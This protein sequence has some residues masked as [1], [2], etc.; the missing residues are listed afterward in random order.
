MITHV[1]SVSVYV[2]DQDAAIDFYCNK[3]GFELR[4]DN[5]MGEGLRWVEVAPRGGQTV[6]IL[7]R[8]YADWS[9]E[10]VGRFSGM[11][12]QPDDVQATYSELSEHGVTFTEAPNQTPWGWQAQFVDQDGNSYVLVQPLH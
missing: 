5:L 9:P 7:V 12:L 1:Q 2:N 4:A 3:L 6:I 11:V 8:G 10:R